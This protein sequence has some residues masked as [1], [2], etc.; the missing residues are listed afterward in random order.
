VSSCPAITP[1]WRHCSNWASAGNYYT[2][3]LS[4]ASV[5]GTPPV[6]GALESLIQAGEKALEQNA[7]AIQFV[8]DMADWD[9]HCNLAPPLTHRLN[10]LGDLYRGTRGIMMD[11]YLVPDKL[12]PPWKKY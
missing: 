4:T 6:K 1:P 11:I 12:Q 9:S 7:R 5:F 2:S 3:F 10:Y 8:R